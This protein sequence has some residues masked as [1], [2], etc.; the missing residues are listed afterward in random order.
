MYDR[1]FPAFTS[2]PS[3]IWPLSL[4]RSPTSSLIL[5]TETQNPRIDVWPAV[6]SPTRISLIIILD[7]WD[8]KKKQF[9]PPDHTD[10]WWC[11]LNVWQK[12]KELILYLR[13]NERKGW[14]ERIGKAGSQYSLFPDPTERPFVMAR[15]PKC[16]HTCL[17]ASLLTRN[18]SP[19]PPA[20]SSDRHETSISLVCPLFICLAVFVRWTA[21]C[22]SCFVFVP[23][24]SRVRHVCLPSSCLCVDSL[25]D[26][27]YS[28][29]LFNVQ[30]PYKCLVKCF[31]LFVISLNPS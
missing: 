13:V 1:Y 23:F 9:L 15:T 27:V 10:W 11:N 17:S 24:S 28:L 26:P 3:L 25:C 22:L 5:Q 14:K 31:M 21:V 2:F 7:S 19:C 6:S 30:R 4:S 29:S 12:N 20:T 16:L 18:S 8:W